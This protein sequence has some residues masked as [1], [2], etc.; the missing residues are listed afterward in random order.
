MILHHAVA[1]YTHKMAWQPLLAAS[2]AHSE[3]NSRV[4]SGLGSILRSIDFVLR[5]GSFVV[6]PA[7]LMENTDGKMHRWALTYRL[8]HRGHTGIKALGPTMIST[9]L[10]KLPEGSTSNE[11]PALLNLYG[12]F[13]TDD[14]AVAATNLIETMRR[15][16]S[17]EGSTILPEGYRS[18]YTGMTGMTV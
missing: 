10:E 4:M 5:R 16:C 6:M 7:Q 13:Y 11:P 17:M 8:G 14:M 1:S 15:V 18:Q 9:R 3:L 12:D 2:A